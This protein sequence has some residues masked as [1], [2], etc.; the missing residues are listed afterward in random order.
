MAYRH[1]LEVRKFLCRLEWKGKS[2][3]QFARRMG[4]DRGTTC[5]ELCRNPA[6]RRKNGVN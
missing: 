6:S 2:Q 5:R 3:A 1:S 4:R